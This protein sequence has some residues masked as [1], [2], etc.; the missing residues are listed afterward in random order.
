[1]LTVGRANTAGTRRART[2]DLDHETGMMKSEKSRKR[3]GKE[4]IVEVGGK[5]RSS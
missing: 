1:M 3:E 5:G 2:M 4:G